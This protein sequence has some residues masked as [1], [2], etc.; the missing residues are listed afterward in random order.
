MSQTAAKP[1]H[2][3]ALDSW[4]GICAL[5]VALYHF[6]IGGWMDTNGLISNSQMFVDFFFVLSGF[7][8]AANYAE[9]LN[10]LGQV[11]RFTWLRIGRLYPLHFAILMAFVAYECAKLGIALFQSGTSGDAFAAPN[12]FHS[13]VSNLFMT[14]GL[15]ATTELTWN[16]PSWSIST[17]MMAYFTFAAIVSVFGRLKWIAFA[18][19]IAISVLV[20][21]V[22]NQGEFLATYDF[23]LFRCYIG[24]FTGAIFFRAYRWTIDRNPDGSSLRMATSTE[25]LSVVAVVLFVSAGANTMLH[26]ALPLVFGAC[27]FF[28]AFD[29][30]AVSRIL[31]RPVFTLLGALSYS[32]YMT[33]V[34]VIDRMANLASLI[35]NKTGYQMI[36]TGAGNEFAFSIAGVP[37]EIV[38]LGFLAVVVGLSFVTYRLIEVPCRDAARRMLKKPAVQVMTAQVERQANGPVDRHVQ[39]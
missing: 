13:L 35:E 10:D 32:V 22:F 38:A 14:Q 31:H 15:G 23:G 25:V 7:V 26:F 9:R 36:D 16:W 19:L 30:G 18:V 17:E 21:I 6:P 27:V 39:A 3:I 33:H 12:D 20:L 5:M 34:F 1:K 2:F 29:Q 37:N 8:I 4:R 24:F 11:G 28:F